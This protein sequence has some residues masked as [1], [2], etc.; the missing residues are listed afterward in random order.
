MPT[1]HGRV[2]LTV[3]KNSNAGTVLRLRGKGVPAGAGGGTG[4]QIV[5]LRIVLPEGGDPDLA[6]FLE[7]WGP[8]HPYD[9]RGKAGMN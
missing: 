7:G 5:R 1:I 9:V 6:A 2:S 3:P 8:L 4:D